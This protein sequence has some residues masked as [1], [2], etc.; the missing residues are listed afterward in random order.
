MSD[1]PDSDARYSEEL[2]DFTDRVLSNQPA[3][4]DVAPT[5]DPELRALK[6]TIAAMKQA[7][8]GGEPTQ[9]VHDRILAR[10]IAEWKRTGLDRAK[11]PWL[12]G[13]FGRLFPR[14]PDRSAW[15]SARKRQRGQIL[16]YAAAGLIVLL[17]AFFLLPAV[18]T[19]LT[20]AALDP[21]GLIP[22]LLFFGAVLIIVIVWLFKRKR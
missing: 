6:S 4:G 11:K 20:G 16:R 18:E 22:A 9:A 17:A 13:I 5:E 10:L 21:V 1:H 14:P 19:G 15:H 12:A 2:A 8:E 7:G 3:P